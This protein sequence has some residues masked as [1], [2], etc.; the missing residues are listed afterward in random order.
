M[1]FFA[2]LPMNEN[3]SAIIVTSHYGVS[4]A[5]PR[6]RPDQATLAGKLQHGFEKVSFW[7]AIEGAARKWRAISLP[8][9]PM[10]P[11]QTVR[12]ID[13]QSAALR[14]PARIAWMLLLWC[15]WSLLFWPCHKTML[16]CFVGL[17]KE[18]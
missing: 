2:S 14:Y 16:M 13:R 1:D 17:G 11:A 8:A 3:G 18:V 6:I 9:I 5:I 12:T 10:H 7:F 15:L 4:S